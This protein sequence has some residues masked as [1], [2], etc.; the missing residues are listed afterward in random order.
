MKISR[1]VFLLSGAV[2]LSAC[3]SVRGPAVQQPQTTLRVDNQA[4]L[5]MTIYV[6]RGSER[7]RMGFAGALRVTLL[8]IPPG[9]VFGA[10][11]LRF[12]ADPIG[13]THAPV[14][15]EITVSPGDEIT[16][17]IPPL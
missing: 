11:P 17:Q 13:S 14:S 12:I 2:L 16:L 1:R 15:E 10:T 9:V 7:R 8:P 4:V 5:D 3:A 6:L